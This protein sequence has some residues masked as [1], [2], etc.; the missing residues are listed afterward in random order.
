MIYIPHLKLVY[1]PIPKVACTSIKTSIAKVCNLPAKHP[2]EWFYTSNKFFCVAKKGM[3]ITN[4]NKGDKFRFAFVRNPFDRLVSCW[5]NKVGSKRGKD[6]TLPKLPRNI[7]F[8]KFVDY[9]IN[10]KPQQANVH[11]RPQYNFLNMKVVDFFGRFETINKDWGT[12]CSMLN[13]KTP[14]PHRQI[15]NH[16]HYSTYY[17]DDLREKIS[18]YYKKDLECFGYDFDNNI[19]PVNR[20]LLETGKPHILPFIFIGI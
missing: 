11:V 12:V 2:H 13:I 5:A 7:S 8:E 15:S 14:L 20:S 6:K 4:P 18:L 9:V 10:V 19:I 3:E 1:Y 16:A 17:T